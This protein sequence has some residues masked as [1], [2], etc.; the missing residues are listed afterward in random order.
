[1]LVELETEYNVK[2]MQLKKGFTNG[3]Q[4]WTNQYMNQWGSNIKDY[5]QM[6]LNKLPNCQK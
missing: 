2:K 4:T 1:M 3:E 5:D 6:R